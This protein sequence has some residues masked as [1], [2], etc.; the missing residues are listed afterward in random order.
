MSRVRFQGHCPGSCLKVIVQGHV[1]RSLSG[2][3]LKVIVQR[4]S[5]KLI[6]QGHLSR[7][8][9]GLKVIAQ[10][11][12]D[13]VHVSTTGLHTA[14]RSRYSS[15]HSIGL[16]TRSNPGRTHSTR[17]CHKQSL[18]SLSVS[19]CVCVCVC[20]CVCV[21]ESVCV[22]VCV[23]AVPT[24]RAHEED[25]PFPVFKQEAPQLGEFPH[26]QPAACNIQ[27]KWHSFL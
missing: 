8:L 7:S 11:Q 22:C 3:C 20:E 4:Q 13:C 10:G 15:S 17:T 14:H 19:V 21:R 18:K 25:D 1:S 16:T 2:S 26:K 23:H 9:S 27:M 6:V 24:S 5:L 12:P